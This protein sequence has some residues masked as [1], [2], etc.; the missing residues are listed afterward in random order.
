MKH[1]TD[2]KRLG[3]DAWLAAGLEALRK[4]GVDSVRVQRLARKLGVTSQSY[5]WHFESRDELLGE[6]L[7]YW[8]REMTERVRD[9]IA[10]IEVPPEERL[11][12][13]MQM[14]VGFRRGYY[15]VAVRAWAAFDAR[16][17]RAVRHTDKVRH[18]YVESLFRE[19]GY[20][21][22]ELETRTRLF[23]IYHS[24]DRELSIKDSTATRRD[25]IDMLHRLFTEPVR[26]A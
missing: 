2:P 10:A 16:A 11:R 21:G 20:R 18:D 5:Y 25:R 15:D 13:L 17:A 23:V 26:M 14:L 6:M 12:A 1:T 7:A 3:R 24:F 8:R 9:A 4:G 19:I 22:K